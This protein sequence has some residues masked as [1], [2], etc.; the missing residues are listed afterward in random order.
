MSDPTAN[1]QTFPNWLTG[2]SALVIIAFSVASPFVFGDNAEATAVFGLLL[3]F[4]TT[5]A[6]VLA[7][8]YYARVTFQD[9]LT[10]YGLQAWRN[11][12]A[13]SLKIQKTLAGGVADDTRLE[14]W[15]LDVDQAKLGWRDL[16]QHVFALQERL[17]RESSEI[18][19]KYQKQLDAAQSA[20][21]RAKIEILKEQELAEK[22]SRAPLP[23]R[24][25]VIV[26]CPEC[27]E[28][29]S[30]LLGTNP[31]DT[32]W[33]DCPSCNLHFPVH[34]A[35]DGEAKIGGT[36]SKATSI[37]CPSCSTQNQLKNKRSAGI[38]ECSEC[39]THILYS[40]SPGHEKVEDLGV[41]NSD[42]ECPYCTEKQTIW[43]NPTK[44]VQFFAACTSCN[45]AIQVEG[46]SAEHTVS[47]RIPTNK[48]A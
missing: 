23:M 45:N 36:K 14:E 17:E 8:R 5:L 9:T 19:I 4:M 29:M 42:I 32:R 18:A 31:S 15:L 41:T 20:E 21:E 11:L 44:P 43:I 35:R 48:E 22:S 40:G 25:P 7:T 3:V 28:K 30:T 37:K 47:K 46:T 2:I 16:L 6:S 12:E 10:R 34:R 26:N 38:I 27:G 39:S 33:L 24:M 1:K 13:L